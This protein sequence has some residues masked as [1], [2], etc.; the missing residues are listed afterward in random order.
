[1]D[2]VV[3]DVPGNVQDVQDVQDVHRARSGQ[4]SGD[5]IES[6]PGASA[7]EASLE[8]ETAEGPREAPGPTRRQEG[9]QTPDLRF[10]GEL[11]PLTTLAALL[12]WE[13][14]QEYVSRAL[15]VPHERLSNR[16]RIAEEG[17]QDATKIICCHDMMGGY[18][19]DR[20]VMGSD[21]AS[22][23]FR[24][25]RCIDGFV[26]FSHW[27]VTIPP[28][29]WVNA[30]HRHGCP[31][32][33]TIITESDAGRELL[34]EMLSSRSK[35]ERSVQQLVNI[36][37]Y[38]RFD[39]WLVNVENEIDVE[40][41]PN[42]LEFVSMLTEAMHRALDHAKVLWYDAVT[43]N[44]T[45]EWQN[46]LTPLNRPFFDRCDGIWINY[47]WK[48]GDPN[49]IRD[50]A[51]E[52]WRDVYLGVDCFGRGTYGGGGLNTYVGVE[53][54]K[55]AALNVGLFAP[56]WP[57]EHYKDGD[58]DRLDV[59]ANNALKEMYRSWYEFDE[60]FWYRI[61][62]VNNRRRPVITM[63]PFSTDFSVGQGSAYY[64]NGALVGPGRSWYNLNLQSLQSTPWLHDSHHSNIYTCSITRGTAFN[65]ANCFLVEGG[66]G[67]PMR[68]RLYQTLIP[69]GG[70]PGIPGIGIKCTA[71]VSKGINLRIA[72][73]ISRRGSK[74]SIMVELDTATTGPVGNPIGPGVSIGPNGSQESSF[75][76][77]YLVKPPSK[78]L[79]VGKVVLNSSEGELRDVKP[80]EDS[81]WVTS[82]FGVLSVDLPAWVWVDGWI[83]SI[84]AVVRPITSGSMCKCNVALGNLSAWF[85]TRDF[86]PCQP[87]LTIFP[88]FVDLVPVRDDGGA[89]RSTH[90]SLM[91]VWEAPRNV[92]RFQ[93]W[94]Q[95]KTAAGWGES[96]FLAAVTVP[97][98]NVQLPLEVGVVAVRFEARTEV[99]PSVQN[100][101]TAMKRALIDFSPLSESVAP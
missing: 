81:P 88:E 5:G 94:F 46:A 4:Q 77:T 52:R 74:E 93:V 92:R 76:S 99:G 78:H 61:D 47:T 70:R 34:E 90:L 41:V 66:V 59:Q 54:A 79:K 12:E 72:L 55:N 62:R 63:L 96:S 35:M 68:V 21:R 40:R 100:S 32:Y 71:A 3:R 69:L 25:W 33:G 31:V 29:C 22:Y 97:L 30:G 53:A 82:D 18:L 80:L 50:A 11:L 16:Q 56:A 17:S 19:E 45:L 42:L 51:G 7:K 49:R 86:P 85:L 28:P 73:K 91:L 8:P 58:E 65:R 27:F 20:H 10:C 13:P 38:Y 6:A 67:E 87:V 39:G 15:Y 1:M 95:C 101:R 64:S 9:G 36:A 37:L 44:G 60:E 48:E 57:Y 14:K 98:Y 83:T 89:I 24:H 23:T 26:Y 43:V 75:A 2:F 84:D